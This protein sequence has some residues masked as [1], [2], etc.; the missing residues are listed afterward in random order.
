MFPVLFTVFGIRIQSYGFFIAIGYLASLFIGTHLAKIRGREVGPFL[1]LA[2]IS[3]FS[4]VLGARLFFVL[5]NWD[6]FSKFPGE[7]IDFWRGGLVFYGGFL[8]AF[9]LNILF[10]KWKKLSIPETFDLCAPALAIGHAIGRIGCLGAGCCHGSICHWPWAVTLNT[11]LVDPALRN[12][13][14]HPTQAYEAVALGSLGIYLYILARKRKLK[15]GGVSLL[16]L[17]G[18]A[19]IRFVVEYFRGDSIR[20]FLFEPW[21]STSQGIAILVFLGSASILVGG[22]RRNN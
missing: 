2:L 10:L 20:G 9:F 15:D 18:Y 3:I 4:G 7:I 14:V 11:D 6:Y 21:I 13:P 22:F 1:D 16:Y 12:I 8:L 19:A 17:M 5:T